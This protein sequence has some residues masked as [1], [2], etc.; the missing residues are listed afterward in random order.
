[1]KDKIDFEQLENLI[2]ELNRHNI[3]NELI[4]NLFQIGSLAELN[5]TQY[6]YLLFI[7]KN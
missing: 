3:P 5:V 6:N 2:F 7:I 1:M 4:L